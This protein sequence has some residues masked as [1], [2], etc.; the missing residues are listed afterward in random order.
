MLVPL[1][2]ALA[3]LVLYP[4][5]RL[6][7]ESFSGGLDHYREVLTD[8]VRRKVLITTLWQSAIVTAVCVLIGYVL[9][10]TLRTARSR[11]AR[12]AFWLAVLVPM[13]MSVVVKNYAWTIILGHDGVLQS[14]THALGLGKPDYLF[15]PVAVV[16]GMVYTLFPYAVLPLF[17]ALLAIPTPVLHAA[18]SLGARRWDVHRTVVLPLVRS[19]LLVTVVLVYVL[20]MGFYVT[21]VVLGGPKSQFV[22]ALVQD[23]VF[24]RFDEGSAAS[25]SVLLLAIAVVVIGVALR[26]VGRS[27]FEEALG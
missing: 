26:I 21:P 15:T 13:W 8:A 18:E 23:D 6:V 7:A 17:I 27:R 12:I 16:L 4:L 1:A 3:L 24:T 5:V 11:S 25:T 19:A 9:A 22:S 2:L 14:A 20:T 10:W